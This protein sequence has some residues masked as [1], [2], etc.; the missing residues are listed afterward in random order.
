MTR[1]EKIQYLTA[2]QNGLKPS[3]PFDPTQPPLIINVKDGVCRVNNTGESFPENE[4]DY[5]RYNSKIA[6][7]RHL[8]FVYRVPPGMDGEG[9]IL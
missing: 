6:K 2:L 1:K 4:L 9:F 8:V 3:L 5:W 7:D